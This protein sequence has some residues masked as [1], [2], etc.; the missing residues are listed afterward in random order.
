MKIPKNAKLVH[1]GIIFDTY[2]WE[3]KMFDGSTATFEM[4][5]RTATVK[6][7]ATQGDK[8]ILGHEEQPDWGPFY[9]L[10]G[11]R[12]DEG[13]KPLD[14]A[15]RELMEEGGFASDDWELFKT[16]EPYHKMNWKIYTYIARNCKQINGQNLDPGEKIQIKL[17]SWEEFL[18]LIIKDEFRGTNVELE[19]LRRHYLGT[20]DE[21]KKKIFGL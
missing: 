16:E 9:D 19:V 3:Q 17:I 1:K 12:V 18:D 8:I 14:C 2:Q 4:L 5:G 6:I 21:L 10:F 7:I 11:G 20:L 13:E 15:K